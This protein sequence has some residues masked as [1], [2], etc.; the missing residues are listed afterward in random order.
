M[1]SETKAIYR[2]IRAHGKSMSE[3]ARQV[4]ISLDSAYKIEGKSYCS[5]CDAYVTAEQC[6]H[7]DYS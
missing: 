2:S 5:T 3:A 4:G 6:P 7:W 1:N